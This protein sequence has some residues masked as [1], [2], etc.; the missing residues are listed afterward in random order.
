MRRVGIIIIIVAALAARAGAQDVGGSWRVRGEL[1]GHVLQGSLQLS[2]GQAF[3]TT[4]SGTLDKATISLIGSGQRVSGDL[5]RG[6]VV[7]AHLNVRAA[8]DAHSAVKAVVPRGAVLDVVAV[9]GD[10]ARVRVPGSNDDR[11]VLATMLDVD[12]TR[13]L[14][15]T[16]ITT[17]GL[18][19][20]IGGDASSIARV[21]SATLVRT[22]D[23]RFD[24][25]AILGTYVG[26]LT[27]ERD[28]PPVGQGRVR[29]VLAGTTLP[30]A[31]ETVTLVAATTTGL[32]RVA[33]LKTDR[34]GEVALDPALRGRAGLRACFANRTIPDAELAARPVART[35]EIDG[36]SLRFGA[37]IPL[38]YHGPRLSDLAKRLEKA[39]WDVGSGGFGW[40]AQAH[41]W[42]ARTLDCISSALFAVSY[43][44]DLGERGGFRPFST[45]NMIRL[46]DGRPFLPNSPFAPLLSLAFGEPATYEKLAGA[47]SVYKNVCRWPWELMRWGWEGTS[48]CGCGLH[49]T[50][51]TI[52]DALPEL[53]E[54]N[55][56][57]MSQTKK[58]PGKPMKE[59]EL[60]YEY[61]VLILYKRP[62]DGAVFTCHSGEWRTFREEV[63]FWACDSYGD[64]ITDVRYMVFQLAPGEV[65]PFFWLDARG[66]PFTPPEI[67]QSAN[68]SIAHDE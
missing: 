52:R 50:P 43:A 58:Q 33:D 20:L 32:A 24:G 56:L 53:G 23:H 14:A 64:A 34:R 46:K 35:T 13:G 5:T 41:A 67:L 31:N 8:P 17:P 1:D 48:S 10:W 61:S 57:S 3:V 44:T 59:W 42:K 47:G 63:D 30:I 40:D 60:E 21:L 62:S 55:V 22:A 65:E 38:A 49:V 26:A 7:P 11:F 12:A 66:R 16:G 29:F 18:A 15:L 6:S 28:P 9:E 27:L 39:D 51:R 2:D 54:I 37:T 25:T 4:F 45:Y 68:A 19:S 36:A